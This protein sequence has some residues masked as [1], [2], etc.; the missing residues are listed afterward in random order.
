MKKHTINSEQ[1]QKRMFYAN[2]YFPFTI[3][4]SI[5]QVN[6]LLKLD[7][8]KLFCIYRGTDIIIGR[9]QII[10]HLQ[11]RRIPCFLTIIY[12][13]PNRKN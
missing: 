8:I 10:K 11:V 12:S 4:I 5:I 1:D 3:S 9:N 7:F 2:K 6:Q 13:V